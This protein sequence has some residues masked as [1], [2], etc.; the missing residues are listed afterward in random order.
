MA[1]VKIYNS[2]GAAVKDKE[3]S[4][5]VFGVPVNNQVIKQVLTAQQANQR[6]NIAHTKDR[7]EVRGGGRKPWRQKGT[8]RAR[9]GSNRSPLWSGGGV[10]FGPT[11]ERN[12]KQ[13]VNKVMRQ[14]AIT[15][16]LSDRLAHERMCVIDQ[17]DLH[18]IKTSAFRKI[19]QALPVKEKKT[20]IVVNE[21]NEV[22]EKSARNLAKVK[23]IKVNNINI[24]D[25]MEYPNMLLTEAAI[26][27]LQNVYGK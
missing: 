8:G 24:R 14:K 27:T 2:S 17:F 18:E 9:H 12:W 25:I 16:A 4:D 1:K 15:M 22:I 11:N 19:L 13:K 7:S 21:K 26:D 6:G 10:T 5:L 20:L 23:M 3:L